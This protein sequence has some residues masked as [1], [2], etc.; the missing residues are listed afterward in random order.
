MTFT[1]SMSARGALTAFSVERA[2]IDKMLSSTEGAPLMLKSKQENLSVHRPS[3]SLLC[4]HANNR[5]EQAHGA[6]STSSGA[7]PL[8]A[9]RAGRGT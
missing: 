1:Y 9:T 5:I 2:K 7:A 4:M 6:R 3:L 8:L